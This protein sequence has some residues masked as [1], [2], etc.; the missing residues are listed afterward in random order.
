MNRK[1]LVGANLHVLLAL[2]VR[3]HTY[4]IADVDL[5][6]ENADLDVGPARLLFTGGLEVDSIPDAMESDGGAQEPRSVGCSCPMPDYEGWL[7]IADPTSTPG[8]VSGTLYLYREGDDF[9]QARVLLSGRADNLQSGAVTEPVD[10]ELTEESQEDSA[11]LPPTDA[12]AT[13]ERWPRPSSVDVVFTPDNYDNMP[14]PEVFGSPGLVQADDTFTIAYGW[15]GILVEVEDGTL[16]NFSAGAGDAVVLCMGHSG[17][18]G[19]SGGVRLHNRTNGKFATITPTLTADGAGRV[20]MVGTVPGATLQITDGDELWWR[21][22]SAN[23]GGRTRDGSSTAT[24]QKAM[25]GAGQILQYLFRQ[26]S[27]RVDF[28]GSEAA[29]QRLDQYNL[30]FFVTD[31]TKIVDLIAEIVGIL[32][33]ALIPGPAGYRV[34]AWPW[35]ATAEDVSATISP[36]LLGG[37]RSSAVAL[38]SSAE[39]YTDV[40]LNYA[41]DVAD[42]VYRRQLWFSPYE[43][44]GAIANPFCRRAY[45]RLQVPG[46]PEVRRTLTLSTEVVWDPGTAS[47]ILSLAALRN[48]SELRRV[49]YQLPQEYNSTSAGDVVMLNDEE[50][51]ANEQIAWV[52][53]APKQAGDVEVTIEFLPRTD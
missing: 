33:A 31:T 15:P 38:S 26:T 40:V 48:T 50:I 20:V 29:F 24:G 53:S 41:Y 22:I 27:L 44:S 12:T 3:G 42:G 39:V 49:A 14:Y 23:R 52:C 46:T 45:D 5:E 51:A 9:T 35:W 6:V 28:V 8:V 13:S 43:Q 30:D 17:T 7:A 34:V 21:S 25:R 11:I 19:Q 32:P 47:A 37:E 18:A 4:W 1:D 2:V 36:S 16:D 10:F